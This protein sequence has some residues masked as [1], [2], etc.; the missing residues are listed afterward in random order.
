MKYTTELRNLFFSD[1][2]MVTAFLPMLE[3]LQN[4]A[5][6]FCRKQNKDISVLTEINV[7]HNQ[8]YHTKNNCSSPIFFSPRDSHAEGLLALIHSDLEGVT[9]VNTDPK[10]K[11]CVL[12]GHFL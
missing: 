2:S 3:I 7:N 9:D 8:I 6:E 12:S 5:L 4:L 11:A 1:F 10:R